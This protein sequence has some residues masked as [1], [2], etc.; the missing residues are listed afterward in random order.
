MS[1][2]LDRIY[3]KSESVADYSRRYAGHLS[4]L[5]SNL[6]HDAVEEMVNAF[7]LARK[8]GKTIYFIGNG[9]SA[10][11]ASHFANDIQIGLRIQPPFKAVSLTDNVSI[12]TALGN[13]EGYEKIFTKQ[14][15]NFVEKDDLLVAISASG[16]SPNL[17]DCVEFAKTKGV[18]VVG[19]TGFDGGKLKALS[20]ISVHIPTEQGEYGPVEDMHMFLDHLIGTYLYRAVRNQ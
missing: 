10:S 9:G 1:N 18:L 4:T 8:N 7:L 11:T 12:L 2:K 3:K 14:L 5:L 13:D 19:L 15:E 17:I 6:D 20:D 16:N